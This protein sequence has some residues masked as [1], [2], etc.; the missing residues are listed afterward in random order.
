MSPWYISIRV[1]AL[2]VDVRRTS[3]PLVQ[4]HVIIGS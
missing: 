3:D 4:G 1:G 2:N